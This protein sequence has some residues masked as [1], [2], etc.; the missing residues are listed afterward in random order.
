MIELQIYYHIK[1][2]IHLDFLLVLLV[3]GMTFLEIFCNISRLK[4]IKTVVDK[5]ERAIVFHSEART[6]KKCCC[7]FLI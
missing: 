7:I 3:A 4:Q 1:V 6:I 5:A 2:L